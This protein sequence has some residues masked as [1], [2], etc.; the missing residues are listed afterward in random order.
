[1]HQHRSS[2]LP[3]SAILKGQFVHN[4]VLIRIPI[5][6]A[7]TTS[8]R[9]G[10]QHRSSRLPH[11]AVIIA[12]QAGAESEPNCKTMWCLALKTIAF[13]DPQNLQLAPQT[14]HN[15]SNTSSHS[16]SES[17]GGRFEQ[18]SGC[19]TPLVCTGLNLARCLH[20][21]QH[22]GLNH[23][24]RAGCGKEVAP[25]TQKQ[26]HHVCVCVRVA[27][28]CL[29]PHSPGM[30][31]RTAGAPVHRWLLVAYLLLECDS[32]RTHTQAS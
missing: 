27:H 11:S 25:R 2:H 15:E 4:L 19:A 24:L 26:S 32:S 8:L 13:F 18:A 30:H 3:Q 22:F 14:S 29:H 5:G 16:C 9:R 10:S 20:G 23:A 7:R 17:S 28:L 6:N 12:Q 31:L 21:W 1:M